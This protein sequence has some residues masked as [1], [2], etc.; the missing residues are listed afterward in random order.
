VLT[1]R[2]LNSSNYSESGLSA[3]S[4][5]TEREG[6]AGSWCSRARA[7]LREKNS[8][9]NMKVRRPKK[10]TVVFCGSGCQT[11]PFDVV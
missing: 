9:E 8:N 4:D 6:K 5:C 10:V 1:K 2:E 11:V 7:H 3:I